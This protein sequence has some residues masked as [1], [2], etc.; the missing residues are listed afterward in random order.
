MKTDSTKKKKILVIDDNSD[1]LLV[2]KKALELK[3][4]DVHTSETF[5]GLENVKK[6][7]PDCIY[8]DISLGGADGREVAQELKKDEKTKHIPI[9]IITGHESAQE[10]KKDAGADDHLSK[11]FE[12]EKLWGMT[13][14]YTS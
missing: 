5:V 7:M 2:M 14:K 9:V 6:M 12:L 4:Y 3:D 1:I 8:L 10:L 13:E 11:P